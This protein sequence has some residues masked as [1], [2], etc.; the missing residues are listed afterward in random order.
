MTQSEKAKLLRDLHH[1]GQILVL[2]NAWDVASA[3]VFEQAG[4]PATA[5]SSAGVAAVFGYPDGQHISADLM[6]DM[7]G[8]I[9]RAVSTP[10]TADLESGYSD[11]VQTALR[12]VELGGAGLNLED[13]REE[14]PATLIDLATQVELIR[15]IRSKT[16]LVI[17]ARTDIYLAGVGDPAT[18][19]ERTVERLNAYRDAGADSLF[20]PGVKDADLI[21]RLVR[22][23]KGPLN[24][25]GVAGGP[26]IS[27]LQQLGVARVSLGSG[28]ARAALGVARRLAKELL[29]QGTYAAMID[30]ALTYA[31]VQ[32]M[33][34][35][36]N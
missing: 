26:L 14:D 27:Q 19:F 23:V 22:A 12:L 3:V 28:P 6:L 31:E 16:N 36:A 35:A 7:V 1:G 32:R 13:A 25:L 30:G 2:P 17:N 5:T 9:I 24:I 20:A 33:L 21:G 8:R 18:R 4:F 11:P 10:V 34:S 15:T 29:E